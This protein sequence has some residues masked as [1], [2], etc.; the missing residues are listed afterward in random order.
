MID[1]THKYENMHR[2]RIFYDLIC[3]N[4]HVLSC[5]IIMLL[6]GTRGRES[7]REREELRE[8]REDLFLPHTLTHG[9]RGR[10][11]EKFFPPYLHM[12]TCPRK[13]RRS[14]WMKRRKEGRRGFLLPLTHACV[15]RR[16]RRSYP[17]RAQTCVG[18]GGR[19]NER[20]ETKRE[21][22]GERESD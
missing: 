11:G 1:N 22:A 2:N 18:R 13:E 17:L 20:R 6:S 8:G 12:D 15:G 7:E 4:N 5:L 10:E 19:R 21:I 9:R 16:G 3:I 14:K